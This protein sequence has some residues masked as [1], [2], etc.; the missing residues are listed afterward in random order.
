MSWAVAAGVVPWVLLGAF[1]LFGIRELRILPPASP[2]EAPSGSGEGEP[3]V[4]VVVPARNEARNIERCLTS[5]TLQDYPDF[6]VIVVDDGSFDGT[7]ELARGV[8]RGNAGRLV[9]IE[10]APLPDGW[11]GKPWACHQGAMAA[12]GRLLL[13]TDADTHHASPLLRRAVAA[14]REDGAR[15]LS[16]MGFQELGGFGERLVQPHLFTLLAMRYRDASRPIGSGESGDAI[17]NGQYILVE[18]EAY[19]GVGGHE[20]VKGEVVEDLRL[21]QV[22]TGAGHTLTLRNAEEDFS[23][24]MYRS[25]R[26]VIDGWTKNMAVGALQAGGRWGR[27]ALPG[28]IAYLVA[29]WVAPPLLLALEVGLRMAGE[30]GSAPLLLWSSLTVGVSTLIWGAIL[31][32]FSVFPGYALLYP[33]GA[34]LA[35]WIALRS[36]WRGRRRI[37]WKGR[38]YGEDGGG[39]A[40]AGSAAGE[41]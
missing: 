32:R 31:V 11:F 14:M 7:G 10:G 29:F 26:E 23:T 38:R 39:P 22:L 41:Q 4:T 37:E 15:V 13:F 12:G 35:A 33:L 28:I 40:A 34:G 8:P 6:E 19:E 16:L 27:W 20:A 36:R 9:V 21:A 3:P 17:A 5:L 30:T 25:L 24:R 18:R 1:L 2:G